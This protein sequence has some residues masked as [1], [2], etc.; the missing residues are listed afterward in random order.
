MGLQ[1]A[2]EALDAIDFLGCYLEEFGGSGL[3]IILASDRCFH[4]NWKCS[5][6]CE[7]DHA[8]KNK[9]YGVIISRK[10]DGVV[11]TM[12]TRADP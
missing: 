8:R 12:Q 10:Y 6:D 9:K 11:R 4:Q 1:P 7:E 5:L 3:K 2:P